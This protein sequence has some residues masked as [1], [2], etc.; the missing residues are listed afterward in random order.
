MVEMYGQPQLIPGVVRKASAALPT[1]AS[2]HVNNAKAPIAPQHHD[3][4]PG[5]IKPAAPNVSFHQKPITFVPV[6]SADTTAVTADHL[7]SRAVDEI[8]RE[9]RLGKLRADEY[10]STAWRPCPLRKTNKRFLNRTLLSMV[11][12][13]NRVKQKTSH[14]SRLKLTELVRKGNE[15]GQREQTSSSKAK[16][17]K[18]TDKSL[19]VI[20]LIEDSD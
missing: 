18:D 7:T 12:H 14:R 20:N 6:S 9:T 5:S 3:F 19:T 13:N 4:I 15:D 10:G 2:Y 8:L 17:S 1:N 11:N 16:T